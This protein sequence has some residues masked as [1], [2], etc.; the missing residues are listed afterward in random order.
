MGGRKRGRKSSRGKSRGRGHAKAR[1]H[2]ALEDASHDLGPPEFQSAR[3]DTEVAWGQPGAGGGGSKA[4][5]PAPP[6]AAG[7]DACR[8]PLDHSLA[9]RAR[10]PGSCSFAL[11]ALPAGD[12]VVP[13]T[14]P[15]PVRAMSC[16]E[17]LTADT[18]F[19]GTV[20][21]VARLKNGPRAAPRRG[22][23]GKKVPEKSL[24]SAG[25]PPQG[26]AGGHPKKEAAGKCTP[27][28]V[29]EERKMVEAPSGSGPLATK[30]SMDSLETV[31]LKLEALSVRANRIYLKLSRKFGQQRLPFVERR[32]EL[33]KKIPGFWRQAFQKHPQL[34][35]FL[36]GQDKEVLSYLN[37]LEVEELGLARL[38]YKIKFYFGPNPYFQNKVLIKEYGCGLSNQVVARST[39]IQWLPGHDLYSM[40]QGNPEKSGSFF[41]WFV[42][43]TSIESDKIV[44]IINE[45]LWPNPLKY[46]LLSERAH[47]E[48][49]KAGRP[50]PAKH[51]GETPAPRAKPAN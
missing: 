46:Y 50:G 13:T 45:E 8:V 24:S 34:S 25:R 15:S 36:S 9:L 43:Q 31:Q 20:G 17:R 18:V 28:S 38:G 39:P 2:A 49:A 44:E 16:L 37:S 14:K 22:P 11:R 32:N 30:G 42:N 12:R 51:P 40:T 4:A 10:A 48:K 26:A 3:E 29:G 35:A 7:P 6:K 27:G 47:G 19:V 5:A 33:I 21:T 41:G 23:S 1:F